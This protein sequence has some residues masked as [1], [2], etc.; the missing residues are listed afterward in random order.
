MQ[1]NFIMIQRIQ[2]AYLLV[3]VI[4]T[5]LFAFLSFA[6]FEVNDNVYFMKVM[7]L[8]Y[9]D[10]SE[11]LF[12][13]PNMSLSAV[14]FFSILLSISAVFN[15]KKRSVQIQLVTLA[16]IAQL[17]SVGLVLF[18]ISTLPVG[19]LEGTMPQVNYTFASFLP[20]AAVVF[21]VLALRGIKKDEKLIKSL[22]RI[23]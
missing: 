18:A 21:L 17:A 14:V 19:I 7:G 22:N 15:F 16:I 6:S 10:T 1:Q 20:I 4:L 11:V 12:E 9:Q 23:R 2:S 3:S 5:F 13:A 8:Y